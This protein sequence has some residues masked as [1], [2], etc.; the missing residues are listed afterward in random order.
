MPL[1]FFSYSTIF[2]IVLLKC[3]TTANGSTAIQNLPH[4]QVSKEF[5]RRAELCTDPHLSR[6]RPWPDI[7]N[8]GCIC[9]L[10]DCSGPLEC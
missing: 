8:G 1:N 4:V 3:I 9:S 5:G 6:V 7:R 2:L 10:F